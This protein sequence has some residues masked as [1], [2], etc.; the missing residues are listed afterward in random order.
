[1]WMTPLRDNVRNANR[2]QI[3]TFEGKFWADI[4]IS[5]RIIKQRAVSSHDYVL[6]T[7]ILNSIDTKTNSSWQTASACVIFLAMGS[8]KWITLHF[9]SLEASFKWWQQ[10]SDW[11]Q[12][13]IQGSGDHWHVTGE[14]HF[15]VGQS[16][17]RLQEKLCAE[18]IW[19]IQVLIHA[20]RRV[21]LCLRLFSHFLTHTCFV[22]QSFFGLLV[23]LRQSLRQLADLDLCTT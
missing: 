15:L 19:V 14:F 12:C 8:W 18:W 2:V 20:M 4:Q 17:E 22:T 21:R 3:W 16:G 1:M 6:R 7:S 5:R 23:S 13:L 10:R 11:W 9:S